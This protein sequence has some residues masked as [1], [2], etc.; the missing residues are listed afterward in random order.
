[1]RSRRNGFSLSAGFSLV[2]LLAVIGI[3]AVLLALLMPALGRAR[4][5]ANKVACMNN[6]RQLLHAQMM[7]VAASGGYLTYPNWG[8]DRQADDV[9]PVG[10]LYA[11]GKLSD[12]LAPD[13]V[14]SGVLYRYL[15]N[16]RVF[17]CPLHDASTA[18][19]GGTDRLTSY[20]MNGAVC[21]YGTV[22]TRSVVPPRWAPSWKITDWRS[23]SE[24]ILWWEAEESGVADAAAFDGGAPWNDGSSYPRENLL[25][26]RH[27]RGACVGCFDGHA[28][29]MD[30]LDFIAEYQRPG[31][32]R[33]YCDP[34]RPDGGQNLNGAF[35]A[36]GN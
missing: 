6:L 7:Y 32:N 8:H 3:I 27:G 29:W 1:M 36:A 34:H 26:R 9:W 31:P 2:E 15:D 17:R 20:I 21:G 22:G 30:R 28:E 33:L 14:K 35:P 12:P 11:Q 24:Q 13:D 18:N 23:P 16:V 25:A 5:E 4:A 19:T 10:W